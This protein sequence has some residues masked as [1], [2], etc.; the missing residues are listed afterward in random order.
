MIDEASNISKLKC[1]NVVM[2][3]II[4]L[5]FKNIF[6]I[7][8]LRFVAVDE[9]S[10]V[11]EKKSISFDEILS[12]D[13]PSLVTKGLEDNKLTGRR[14]LSKSVGASKVALAIRTTLINFVSMC[15]L[16]NPIAIITSAI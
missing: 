3:A 16:E 13:A 8:L 15:M 11:L 6:G 12:S 14:S 4:S 1:V 2:I 7:S 5:H 10:T 9:L